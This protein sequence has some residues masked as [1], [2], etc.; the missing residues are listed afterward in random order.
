MSDSSG[1]SP[2]KFPGELS[3]LLPPR[4]PET[5]ERWYDQ[6]RHAWVKYLIIAIAFSTWLAFLILAYINDS[7]NLKILAWMAVIVPLAMIIRIMQWYVLKDHLPSIWDRW[8][9]GDR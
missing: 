2:P 8:K 7:K 3:D 1:G 5:P 6:L 9:N 4:P